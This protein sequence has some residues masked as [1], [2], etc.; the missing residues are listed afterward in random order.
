MCGRSMQTI[1]PAWQARPRYP[2]RRAGRGYAV[3]ADQR[4]RAGRDPGAGDDRAA[5][6]ELYRDLNRNGRVDG[7]G[8]ALVARGNQITP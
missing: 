3:L 5:G 1:G 7:P 8:D 4:E 2:C 6:V